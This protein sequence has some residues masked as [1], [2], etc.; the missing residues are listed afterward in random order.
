MKKLLLLLLLFLCLPAFTYASINTYERDPNTLSVPN[1]IKVTNSNKSD[2]LNTPLVDSKEKI[3]DFADLYTDSEELELFSKVTNFINNYNMDMVIVTINGHT[4]RNGNAYADDFFDYNQFGTTKSR[5]GVV[6][7]IDIKE[8]EVVISTSGEAILYLDDERIDSILDSVYDKLH[9]N[10]YY[11]GAISF[12]QETANY[13]DYGVPES[14]KNYYI[15]ESG[16]YIIR[17][18]KKVNFVIS[19]I[20]AIVIASVVVF[21]LKSKHKGIKLSHD[22]EYYFDSTKSKEI[23]KNDKFISTHTSR[24][25]IP[26]SSGGGS[27]GGS[28]VHSG[29]SGRSHGGGSRHF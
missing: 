23:V 6:Y 28:S 13:V 11:E 26:D 8:R 9:Y 14:N 29:S 16:N 27:H 20:S 2:I 19:T 4:K 17:K 10:N 25:R 5:D 24:T 18:E 3:Y 12:I 15:D 22:A 7:L 21:I 1:D